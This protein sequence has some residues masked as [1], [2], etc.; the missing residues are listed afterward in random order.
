MKEKKLIMQVATINV[1]GQF[2]TF[3]SISMTEHNL[4]W[5]ASDKQESLDNYCFITGWNKLSF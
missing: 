3:L 5:N 4:F 2:I 1:I